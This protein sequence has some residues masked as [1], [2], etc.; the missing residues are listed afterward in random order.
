MVGDG[1]QGQDRKTRAWPL[2][3][4][5]VRDGQGF[6]LLSEVDKTAPGEGRL[7]GRPIL[8]DLDSNGV[9]IGEFG[10]STQ[11]IAGKDGLQ[12]RTAWAAAGDGVLF[13]DPDGR[14]AIT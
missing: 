5:V 13:F 7:A 6:A 8:L 2:A 3:G 4:E 11:T 12:H 14:N 9:R 10:T 1:S